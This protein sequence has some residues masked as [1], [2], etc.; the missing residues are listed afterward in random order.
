[1]GTNKK[2]PIFNRS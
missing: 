1:M 2:L